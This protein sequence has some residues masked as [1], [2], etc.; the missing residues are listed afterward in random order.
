MKRKWPIIKP[1][2]RKQGIS[3]MVDLGMV[4]G[5]RP[6]FFFET[7]REAET[8]ADL[9]RT[10]RE[11]EGMRAFNM[12]PAERDDALGALELL[13]PHQVTLIQAARFYLSNTDII[14]ANKTV[15]EAVAELLEAKQQDGRSEAH[16]ADLRARLG[17]FAR[18]F[19]TRLIHTL[20]TGELE[21]WLRSLAVGNQSRNNYRQRLSIL[22]GFAV[23]RRYALKNPVTAI[24]APTVEVKKP[25]ILT[26][27]EV[28]KLLVA[29]G[30]E[31]LPAIAL[32][33]FAG[34]RPQSEIWRLDWSQIDLAGRTIQIEK[35][36]NLASHRFVKISD[37]LAEWLKP[38]AKTKGSVSPSGDVFWVYI[39]K[40]RKVAHIRKWP[41]DCLRHSYASYHLALHK[42]AAELASE[43]GHGQSLGML[44]R[45]YR[46][47]VKEAEASEYW[48]IRP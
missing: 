38:Y 41:S 23:K 27:D 25:G 33:A 2:Q 9:L 8:K 24:D 37:N 47:R 19:G 7:K 22:F 34:L 45:H 4:N 3:W 29:A 14:T 15:S 1:I 16:L 32:G 5:K 43:L 28:R 6:R 30:P 10:E 40:A 11:N 18:E 36:K 17:V 13:S 20:G 21:D 48:E 39:R 46:N 42:N 35:S 44:F 26:P 12:T 31:I